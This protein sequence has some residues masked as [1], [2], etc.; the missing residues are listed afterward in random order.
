MDEVKVLF[1]SANP[2]GDLQLEKELDKIERKIEGSQSHIL[3]VYSAVATRED[4]IEQLNEHQPHIIHFS[5]H[6]NR[7]KELV[8]VGS[9]GT[10]KPVNDD[11][12]VG[13]LRSSPPGAT[14][15]ELALNACHSH[16]IAE[17]LIEAGVVNFAIGMS[18]A[19]RDEAAIIFS[20]LFI[21]RSPTGCQSGSP[22]EQ[23]KRR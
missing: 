11:A 1:F 22:F 9:D 13:V 16:D 19:I 7:N 21:G 6:G 15:W 4:F 2:S 5:G 17:T 3:K 8:F 10:K 12:L 20:A 18:D 14:S 23:A